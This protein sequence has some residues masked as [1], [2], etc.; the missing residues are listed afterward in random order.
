MPGV[1]LAEGIEC[2]EN[3]SLIRGAWLAD[4]R[5]RRER[6]HAQLAGSEKEI[7]PAKSD[8]RGFRA[9][10]D[11]RMPGAGGGWPRTIHDFYGFPRPLYEVQYPAPGAPAEAKRLAIQHHLQTDH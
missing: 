6:I 3:A 5:D 2:D 11:G 7:P 4:E 1:E 10:G 9:L 8:L